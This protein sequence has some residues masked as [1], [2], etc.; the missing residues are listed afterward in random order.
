MSC[1]QRVAIR[2]LERR[3]E[4]A[5]KE[6]ILQGLE[7]RWGWRDPSANPDLDDLASAYS[8]ATF[9]VAAD[10]P[11]IIGTGALVNRGGGTAEIVRMSVAADRRGHG[12]GTRLLEELV[13][14]AR[15][16]GVQRVILETTA[17]WLDAIEFYQRRG[18]RFTHEYDGDAYFVIELATLIDHGSASD[19]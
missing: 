12:I 15:R 14:W 3:D 2:P 9:L 18:F 8:Q 16:D 4:H 13:A 11:T 19:A 10:G 6:L 1:G 17:T 7:E 5:A